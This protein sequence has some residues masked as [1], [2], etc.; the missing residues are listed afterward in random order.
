MNTVEHIPFVVYFSRKNDENSEQLLRKFIESYLQHPAGYSHKLFFIK[1]GY[2]EFE[3][4]WQKLIAPLSHIDFD[5]MEVPDRNYCMGYYRELLEQY[6]NNY[7]LFLTAHSKILVDNWLD[8]YMR[9]ANINRILGATAAYCSLTKSGRKQSFFSQLLKYCS[10]RSM[11][12]FLYYFGHDPNK[13]RQFSM[14][15]DFPSISMRTN[16][17]LVPPHILD[18][19]NWPCSKSIKTKMDEWI[20]ESGKC[21]FSTQAL[22]SG[23]ELFVVGADGKKYSIDSWRES[24]TFCSGKQKNLIIGDNHTEKYNNATPKEKKVL[25]EMNWGRNAKPQIEKIIQTPTWDEMKQQLKECPVC[26]TWIYEKQYFKAQDINRQITDDVFW[27]S[28]CNHC[29]TISIDTVPANLS[30]YYSGN[31]AP[32]VVEE[33]KAITKDFLALIQKYV[34]ICG[35]YLELGPG[36]GWIVK[37]VKETGYRASCIEMDKQCCEYL[38]NLG[39]IEVICSSEPIETLKKLNR[40]WDCIFASHFFEHLEKPI[41]MLSEC[42]DKLEQGGILIFSVPDIESLAFRTFRGQTHFLI[43][44][45]RHLTFVTE[46]TYIEYAASFGLTFLETIRNDA[47]AQAINSHLWFSLLHD[48]EKDK[49]GFPTY[50]TRFI[51]LFYRIYYLFFRGRIRSYKQR[52]RK[53]TMTT[54]QKLEKKLGKSSSMTLVF[55]KDTK[56]K[57]K[58]C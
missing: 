1:K 5:V 43:D 9:H 56:T 49:R 14:F 28:W 7:F 55:R 45:P 16:A 11:G 46:K 51:N 34:N 57:N 37:K 33:D 27:Y 36:I 23:M 2:Q 26:Q 25:R 18:K 47:I 17:F 10:I 42:A 24:E 22:K 54:L 30:L 44:A 35:S 58:I 19:I 53:A 13:D 20:F 12:R 50:S 32:Y 41:S 21:G 39:E 29:G 4:E 40:S 31:Y 38:E 48:M 8:L 6:P 15:P 3:D 52:A